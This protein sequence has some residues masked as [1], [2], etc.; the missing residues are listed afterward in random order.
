MFLCMST[1]LARKQVMVS[2]SPILAIS[3][4]VATFVIHLTHRYSVFNDLLHVIEVCT[5]SFFA[6][7]EIFENYIYHFTVFHL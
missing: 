2:P 3:E 5:P 1:F 7:K 6:G 4:Y